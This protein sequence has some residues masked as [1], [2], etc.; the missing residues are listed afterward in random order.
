MIIIDGV[1][2][3]A[4]LDRWNLWCMIRATD[5]ATFEAQA[6][7]VKLKVHETPEVSAVLDPETGDVITAAIPASGPL[8]P[9]AGVTITE[10]GP[11]VLVPAM[12]DADGEVTTPAFMDNRHHVNFWLDAATVARGEWMQWAT[13]W[14]Y[15]GKAIVP[16]SVEDGSS[17]Y[18][19]E[20]IDP[21]TVK[22]PR[23]VLL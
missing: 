4:A 2:I 12:L 1:E 9:T 19:I 7:A 11:L 17:L 21:A 16:N 8:V 13:D 15:Y 23:N 22:Q 20:L 3:Y 6:L 18:G 14:T 10:M 5:K